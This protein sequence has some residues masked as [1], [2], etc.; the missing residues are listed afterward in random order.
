MTLTLICFYIFVLTSVILTVFLIGK[1]RIRLHKAEEYSNQLEDLLDSAPDGYFYEVVL[2]NTSYCYCSRRLCLMLD[3]VDKKASFSKLLNQLDEEEAPS[4]AESYQKL[5]ETQTP[6]DINVSSK[7]GLFH[8]T[9]SG[10]V[11]YTPHSHSKTFVVWFKDTTAKTALLIE[12]RQA[13]IHLLKQREILTQTLNALPFPL[14]MQDNEG[15]ICFENKVYDEEKEDEADIHW[16]EIPLTLNKSEKKYLLKYGQDKTTEEGLT[17]LLNDANRAHKMLLKEL[18][19]GIIEF[20]A[21]ARLSYFNMAFSDIW[22]IEPHF[23]KKNPSFEEL[24]DKIQEKGILPQ[25][26]DFAQY[27]KLQLSTFAQL[28]KTTEDFL[29]LSGG[30]IVRRLIIPGAKGSILILDEKKNN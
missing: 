24:L 10:R 17:A 18:P 15:A 4:I 1:N 11:L 14:Y 23:L 19:Y 3:T 20:D 6:F 27:K 29:Y 21:T 16:V 9:L 30:K 7:H 26:K 12:E 2:K 5:K 22:G 13:Y 25:V 8:F 28:T